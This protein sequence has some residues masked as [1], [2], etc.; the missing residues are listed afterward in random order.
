MRKAARYGVALALHGHRH[1]SFIWKSTVYEAP[2]E[3]HAD[4][5]CGELTILGAGS[6]GSVAADGEARSFFNVIEPSPHRLSIEL[7]QAK[8]D[9]EVF[10]RISTMEAPLQLSADGLIIQNW[11]R[12]T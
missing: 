12:V 5:K 9:E 4:P 10:A 1:R 2:E 3:L 11:K 7:Y 8:R 6:A